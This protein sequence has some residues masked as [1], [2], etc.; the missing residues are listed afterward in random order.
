MFF[1]RAAF[2]GVNVRIVAAQDSMIRPVQRLQSEHIRPSSVE[3][4]EHIDTRPKMLL[5]FRHR[6]ARVVV[7]AVGNYV[8][9]VDPCH[10][11][12]NFGMHSGIIVTGK[13]ASRFVGPLRHRR[14]CS[15]VAGHV[16]LDRSVPNLSGSE[17]FS[18]QRTQ[19]TAAKMHRNMRI[20]APNDTRI[21]IPF[22]ISGGVPVNSNFPSRLVIIMLL[23]VLAAA[24]TAEQKTAR[25]LDSIRGQPPLLLAFLH[26]M[27]K[28]GDL[29]NHL[30]G[31]IYA[32]DLL[33]FAASDNFC[34]DRT[35][36]HLLGAPC[37]SC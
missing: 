26:D 11:L 21:T 12:Q 15:R 29:H 25:Y 35:T 9:A 7:I 34:V 5:E 10:G 17:P 4:K 3:R 37:D 8:S 19:R 27:P 22:L 20:G 1:R 24:Q 28:G 36:S 14:E 2:V 32:E 18:P 23:S 6:R 31:A 33:G 30:D 13:V 16:A